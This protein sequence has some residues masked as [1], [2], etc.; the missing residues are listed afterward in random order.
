M[1]RS[2]RYKPSTQNSVTIQC[3]FRRAIDMVA[4]YVHR[5]NPIEGLSF[6]EV[7]AI[8][9]STRKG[10]ERAQAKTWGQ[11]GA[12]GE[13][14][15]KKFDCYWPQRCFRALMD[16]SK[17]KCSRMA[18]SET[19][20]LRM[21]DLSAVVQIGG[22]KPSGHRLQRNWLS[23]TERQAAEVGDGKRWR[24][25]RGGTSECVRRQLPSSSRAFTLL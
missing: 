18:T 12:T 6:A 24:D 23:H 4:V 14:K 20:L 7:D 2:R 10:G 5:N 25:G 11:L 15:E 3:W 8:F 17:R 21:L 9:S 19:G 22:S 16:S 13:L 1:R